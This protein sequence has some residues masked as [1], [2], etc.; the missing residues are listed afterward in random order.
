MIADYES[1]K[2]S[3]ILGKYVSR[4]SNNERSSLVPGASS[5][6]THASLPSSTNECIVHVLVGGDDALVLTSPLSPPELKIA[7]RETV[8]FIIWPF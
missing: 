6:L 4:R 2:G 3:F 8:S 7:R 5:C 1:E